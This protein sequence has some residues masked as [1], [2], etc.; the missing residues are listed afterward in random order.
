MPTGFSSSSPSSLFFFFFFFLTYGSS[1]ARGQI[2]T[3]AASLHHRS[4]QCWILNPLS[5]AREPASSW[6]L[7]AF[8]SAEPQRNSLL[9]FSFPH[10]NTLWYQSFF[11]HSPGHSHEL[12]NLKV[13]VFSS[14][15]FFS[16]VSLMICPFHCLY[17]LCKSP[18]Q[19]SNFLKRSFLI[20]HFIAF[21]CLTSKKI[22]STLY[23]KPSPESFI[24]A[25]IFLISKS[26]F[27]F[28][29]FSFFF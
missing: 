27:L 4:Q 28:S 29:K 14:G 18:I 7:V 8:I 11:S 6:F 9:L 16:M 3:T 22:S 26:S 12:F 13:C 15:N 24:S 25:I 23:S 2:S 10:N 21:F 5:K 19:M 20:F 1:Q 17:S